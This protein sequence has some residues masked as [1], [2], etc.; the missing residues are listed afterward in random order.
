L[1][2]GYYDALKC[3][4]RVHFGTP[5][6]EELVR[7]S[8]DQFPILADTLVFDESGQIVAIPPVDALRDR[9]ESEERAG[10]APSG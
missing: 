9:L 8:R 4:Y 7:I 5:R 2:C 3:T 1:K 6:P 10:V